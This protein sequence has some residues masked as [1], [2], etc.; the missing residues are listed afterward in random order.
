M[1]KK[2]NNHLVKKGNARMELLRKLK[3]FGAPQSDLLVVYKTFVRSIIEQS[4]CVWHSGLTLEQN[5]N[6]ERVQKTAL[7][8]ILQDR[9]KSYEDALNILEL[10]TLHDRR[11]YLCLSFARKCLKN[12]KNEES[13]PP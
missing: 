4:S 7:K 6:L 5:N 12:E 9:Y 3:S 11:E 2:N 10:E 1:G 8:L 13:V